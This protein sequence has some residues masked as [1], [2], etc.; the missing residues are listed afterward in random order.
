VR[1]GDR[2]LISCISACGRCPYRRQG[3]CSQCQSGGWILGHLID[4]SDILPTGFEVGVLNGNVRT[5]A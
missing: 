3:M 1:R 2:V 5:R 4:G